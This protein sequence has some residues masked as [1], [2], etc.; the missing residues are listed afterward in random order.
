MGGGLSF[1][2]QAIYGFLPRA[3]K[4]GAVK[5]RLP[6]DICAR[7]ADYGRH[8]ALPA[9]GVGG[10]SDLVGIKPDTGEH[11]PSPIRVRRR[12]RCRGDCGFNVAFGFP[13]GDGF[14]KALP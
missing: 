8:Y 12:L 10:V 5:A 9:D 3:A 14:L 2:N 4:A 13:L 7:R 1:R 6:A 11:R